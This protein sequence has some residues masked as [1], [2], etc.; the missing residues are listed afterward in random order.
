MTCPTCKFAYATATHC[1]SCGWKPGENMEDHNVRNLPHQVVGPSLAEK[2]QA[3]MLAQAQGAG[4]IE[5]PVA[6]TPQPATPHTPA[7]HAT[8]QPAPTQQNLPA[9]Q[10]P[11]PLDPNLPTPPAAGSFGF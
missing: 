11:V 2:Q 4:Y 9:A 6:V 10:V 8:P 7:P 5:T 3:E 1:G